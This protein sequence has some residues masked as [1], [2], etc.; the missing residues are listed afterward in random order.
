MSGIVAIAIYWFI[1]PTKYVLIISTHICGNAD[2]RLSGLAQDFFL[3][4]A[5]DFLTEFLGKLIFLINGL[6]KKKILCFD[7]IYCSKNN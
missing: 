6:F 3:M 2:G 5:R 4:L 1:I 7:L